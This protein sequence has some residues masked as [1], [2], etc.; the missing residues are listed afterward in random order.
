[1][2]SEL[3]DVAWDLHDKGINAFPL[4]HRS[5]KPAKGFEWKPLTQRRVTEDE[6]RQW[7]CEK[8]R[9]N[10]A[11][12]CGQIS[13]VAAVDA[14]S[15]ENA[16]QLFSVLPRTPA[17][18]KTPNGGHF[19]FR[20]PE[21]LE[22]P[23]SVKTTVKGIQADIRGEASYI[24]IAPSLHPTGKPY[25]WVN[26]SWNLNDVPEFD[27]EWIDD[28]KPP[29]DTL[30]NGQTRDCKPLTRGKIRDVVRYMARVESKQG[31]DGSGGLIRAA[32]ICRD[33]GYSEAEA[34]AALVQWNQ[35][36][37]VDPEWSLFGVI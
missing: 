25:Q 14:D 1:V 17:M 37:T 7:F 34:M 4:Q 35:G 19:L 21:G 33:A 11:L 26:W 16:R 28:C 29:S 30:V 24:V 2:N 3:T 8:T 20:L 6:I 36:S 31:E 15:R 22:V 23:P 13:G 5:K 27:P 18:Q 10:I 12:L 9:T 32:A